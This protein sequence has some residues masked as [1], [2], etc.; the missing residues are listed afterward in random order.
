[1]SA[2]VSGVIGSGFQASNIQQEEHDAT[3]ALDRRTG[4]LH[5]GRAADVRTVEQRHG[6]ELGHG[7][8]AGPAK[9]RKLRHAGRAKIVS[10]TAD[11][12]AE[13]LSPETSERL[14][15]RAAVEV[16]GADLYNRRV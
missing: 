3:F 1:M 8:Y 11:D 15:G 14:I 10:A 7:L 12:A 16:A 5:A 2:A 9:S 6:T 4:R 13:A